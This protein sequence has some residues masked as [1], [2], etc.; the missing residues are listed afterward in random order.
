MQPRILHIRSLIE[1]F[2]ARISR[3][4]AGE[5][6]A[7]ISWIAVLLGLCMPF[8]RTSTA[9]AIDEEASSPPVRFLSKLYANSEAVRLDTALDERFSPETRLVS[10]GP[11][12]DEPWTWQML[13]EGLLYKSYIAGEKEPR[14]ADVFV[15]EIGGSSFVDTTL[16][17]RLGIVRY[18]VKRGIEPEGF[19]IDVEGGSFIRSTSGGGNDLQSMDLRVGVPVTWREGPFQAKLSVYHVESHVVDDYLMAHPGFIPNGYSR[20]AFVAGVGYFLFDDL[21]L[22]SEVGWSISGSGGDRPWEWQGGFEWASS[23]PTGLRGAPYVAVNGHLREA[24]HGSGS[25]NAIAGWQWRRSKSEHFFRVGLQYFNGK[26]NQ[27]SFLQDNQQL[28]GLGLRYDY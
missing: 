19:Q 18:G 27:Y 26:N 24:T 15:N 28:L 12:T 8:L 2:L 9:S 16:G 13:P 20:T 6:P 17:W 21:R 3:F 23:K 22:Y 14:I 5:W 10:T 7:A 11:T 1:S 25:I 4:H